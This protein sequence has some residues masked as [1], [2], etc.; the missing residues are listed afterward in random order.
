VTESSAP[1]SNPEVDV[2]P[3]HNNPCGGDPVYLRSGKFFYTCNDLSVPGRQMD[4]DLNHT[5]FSGMA[6]NGPFGSNWMLG[7]Y[8][9]LQQ[10]SDGSVVI[11]SGDGRKSRYTFDG[12]QY[13]P[14][15]GRFE[16]LVREADDSW[17]LTGAQGKRYAFDVLGRLA[18]VKDRNDNTISFAYSAAQEP[19]YGRSAFSLNPLSSIVIQSDY[20]ITR[21]T[22][23]NGRQI[24]LA[25]NSDGLLATITDNLPGGGTRQTSFTYDPDTNDLLSVTKPATAEY[26]SGV[27][28]TFTYNEKHE[29]TSITDAKG[30]TFAVNSYDSEGRVIHQDYGYGSFTFNY[31]VDQTTV[32]GRNGNIM[33]MTF[34]SNGNPVQEERFTSGVR[35]GDPA[36]YITTYTYNNDMLKTSV[37]Y[38]DGNGI[39]YVYDSGNVD[40]RA[41]GNLLQ[42]RRKANMAAADNDADDLVTNIIYESQFNFP[43]TVTDP[44]GN[45]TTF[46]YDY[47]LLT[48]DPRYGTAGNLVTVTRPAVT[49]G[50]PE[51]QITYNANGQPTLI[52]DA[53]GNET[54][55]AY[56]A[57]T[58]YPQTVTRDPGGINAVT[59]MTFDAY[60]NLDTV[61][62]PNSHTV[63]LDYNALGWLTRVTNPLGYETNYT[64][65]AN[66]NVTQVDRQANAAATQWQTVQFAYDI[67]NN[68]TSITDPLSRATSYAYD[69]SENLT[70]VTDPEL[71]VTQYA[72]DER[73]L[74]YTVIDA[75][76]P[77]GVTQRD[78]TVNGLLEAIID[79]NGN[80]TDYA[81]DGFDRLITKTYA[82]LTAEQ[83][84]YDKNSNLSRLTKPDAGVIDFGYDELNRLVAKAFPATPNLDAAYSYDL[85]SRLLAADTA[86]SAIGYVYDN[87][88]RVA[89]TTQTLNP[90][91]PLTLSYDYDDVGNQIQMTYPSGKV[92]DYGYDHW[93]RMNNITVNSVSLADYGYDT[94]DRRTLKSFNPL[95][96]NPLNAD[97]AYDMANQLSSITNTLLPATNISNYVYPAYDGVGNRLG[98]NKTVGS[99]PMEMINYGYNNIYELN[100]VTGDQTH[101]YAYDNVGN[102]TTA[103]GTAYLNNEL[104]QYTTVGAST[105]V[106]DTNGNLT[107]DGLNAYTFDEQNRLTTFTNGA[108]N[109]SYAYDA[110]NRRV[111]KTVNGVTT[112]FIYDADEVIAEYDSTNSLLAEYVYG[113]SIDE[114][115]TMERGGSTYY[116]HYDGL[117]GCPRIAFLQNFVL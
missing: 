56:D 41:R 69:V 3:Q 92:V 89:S 86:A 11:V 19:I 12:A 5:Y 102:R 83:Y 74:L 63:D 38:P 65:D 22:D 100:S 97:Y 26:P 70:S 39:K 75:N 106:H 20:R 13:V 36:S 16:T 98:L 94:L 99:L 111:S 27:T 10:M 62:D 101:S 78:Y 67:L 44:K 88:N 6:F 81:Y 1:S 77:A 104:N 49:A 91:N 15:A 105:I 108:S 48:S 64:H 47:E 66:G 68:L 115:L 96:P 61:T 29:V 24:D 84:A 18:A 42:L 37:T 76:T 87:L 107:D 54:A 85:G 82:N 2:G 30:Q 116:Y 9:R 57:A 43:K 31:G 90:L 14:P 112:Y 23:T 58:G 34:N 7:Y 73:D 50:T 80:V 17:T 79:A 93:D 33:T 72:Y 46:T 60:G 25:Y 113:D 53:N 4:L 28:K 55:Y 35:T 45:V 71:N 59:Q 114:V 52:A 117:G 95:T 40:P 110:F 109:A 51:I 32:T 8:M 103:D 21:I